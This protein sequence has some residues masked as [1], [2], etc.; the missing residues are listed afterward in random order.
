MN[1]QPEKKALES[2]EDVP[3]IDFEQYIGQDENS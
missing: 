1:S 2:I 3:V